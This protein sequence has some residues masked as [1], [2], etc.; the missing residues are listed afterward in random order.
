[1]W[2]PAHLLS[3]EIFHFKEA[4]VIYCCY[5]LFTST[6]TRNELHMFSKIHPILLEFSHFNGSQNPR[7]E[8]SKH[9]FMRNGHEIKFAKL[10]VR[11]ISDEYL[12]VP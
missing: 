6:L 12:N 8:A 7:R 4:F 9:G 11:L 1:M 3:H 2:Y 5:T 10:S